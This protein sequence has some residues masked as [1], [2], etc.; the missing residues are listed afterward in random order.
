MANGNGYSADGVTGARET[1]KFKFGDE[2]LNVPVLHFADLE[3]LEEPILAL[4]PGLSFI[5]HAKHVIRIVAYQMTAHGGRPDLTEDVLKNKMLGGQA[6][7]ATPMN[8]L[9]RLSGFPIP[10]PTPVPD[11]EASPGIGMSTDAAPNSPS[12]A[13]A[14]ETRSE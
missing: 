2:E 12:E 14:A 1:V 5:Q 13:S 8:E 7:L 3:Q 10:E 9:L 6:F 11:P 4:G